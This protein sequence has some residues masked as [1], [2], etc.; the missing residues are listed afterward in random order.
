MQ[1]QEEHMN[2]T[3]APGASCQPNLQLIPVQLDIEMEGRKMK[4]AFLWDKSEPYWDMET[5]ARIMVEEAN[6]PA[7]FEAEIVSQMRK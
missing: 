7:S 3:Y 2:G 4:D 6:L 1:Q 5:F